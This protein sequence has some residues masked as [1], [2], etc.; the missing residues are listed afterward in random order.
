M[1][2]VLHELLSQSAARYPD[3]EAVRLEDAL[4]LHLADLEP[5]GL[6]PPRDDPL[7]AP[8]VHAKA[9]SVADPLLPRVRFASM[10]MF[11]EEES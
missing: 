6:E 4:G 3:A 7:D 5:A 8:A 11:P 9:A 10:R 2:Y 1:A